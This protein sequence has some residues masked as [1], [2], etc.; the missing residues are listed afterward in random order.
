[1]LLAANID[2]FQKCYRCI[3]A[4]SN[5]P[6]FGIKIDE[7][8]LIVALLVAYQVSDVAPEVLRMSSSTHLNQPVIRHGVVGH[9]EVARL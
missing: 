6:S 8:A 4:A 9:V 1:M 5:I 3:C 2:R 7:G